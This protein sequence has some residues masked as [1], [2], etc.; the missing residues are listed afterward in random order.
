MF[1]NTDEANKEHRGSL[2][3]DMETIISRTGRLIDT[4]KLGDNAIYSTFLCKKKVTQETFREVIRK[5][6]TLRIEVMIL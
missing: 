5:L 4:K 6:K 2:I 1:C 3:L